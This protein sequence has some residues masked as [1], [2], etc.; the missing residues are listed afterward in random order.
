MDYEPKVDREQSEDLEHL[1]LKDL[2]KNGGGTAYSGAINML[3]GE[4]AI[5][6]GFETRVVAAS[7]RSE[8]LFSPKMIDSRL[9]DFAGI[10]VKLGDGYRLFDPA[11]KYAPFGEI[12][13]F[14]EDAAALFVSE[15]DAGWLQLPLSPPSKNL[16]KR[17]A[18]LK[19]DED[20]TLSGTVSVELYG[21][22]ALIYRNDSFRDELVK[23]QKDIKDAIQA[24]MTNA[25]ITN[26]AIENFD[27]DNTKPVIQRYTIKVP[28]Y[29]QKTGKR[30]FFQPGFFE[31]GT[32]AKF[33]NSKRRNDIFFPYP[34]SENDTIEIQFPETYALDNPESPGTTADASNVSSD[35]I[36]IKVNAAQSKLFYSRDFSFGNGGQLFFE[37]R[38]YPAV[39]GLWDAIQKADT[40]TLSIKLKI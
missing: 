17:T 3:F 33:A 35:K 37:V 1:D 25:E 22:E 19:L 29:A 10:G 8:V 15:K 20:G 26:I 32:P 21:Q 12:P 31:Y 30:L 34:W 23:K 16:T 28:N 2:V 13:W 38:S 39:K 24:R 27:D 36:V 5:S 6:T 4:M 11:N 40:A 7:N 9:I 18:K 14:R